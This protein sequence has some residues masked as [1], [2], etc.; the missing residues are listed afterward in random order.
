M[1]RRTVGFTLIELLVVVAIIMVLI[2]MLMPA[3]SAAKQFAKKTKAKADIKQLDTAWVSVLSDFR[4]W[5]KAN[6]PIDDNIIGSVANSMIATNVNYLQGGN[7]RQTVYMDFDTSAT[8]GK[9]ANGSFTD[10]WYVD[11][12]KTPNNIYGFSLGQSSVATP[13]GTIYR[14]V[15]SWSLG[16]DATNSSVVGSW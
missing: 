1:R 13:Q 2:A 15:A 12:T 16:R 9:G 14:S 5:D 3:F 8:N 7:P 11:S 4:T 6:L 10:P